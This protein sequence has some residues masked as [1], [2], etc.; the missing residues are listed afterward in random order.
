MDRSKIV[1]KYLFGWFVVDLISVLPFEMLILNDLANNNI[2]A[3]KMVPPLS[4]H[5][6]SQCGPH[7]FSSISHIL[8]FID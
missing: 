5:H 3:M 8:L 4:P 6:S 2:K 7:F 1:R